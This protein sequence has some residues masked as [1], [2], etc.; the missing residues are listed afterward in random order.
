MGLGWAAYG[1]V[2][3]SARQMGAANR[4]ASRAWQSQGGWGGAYREIT[5]T[6]ALNKI[7]DGDA[8]NDDVIAYLR[9]TIKPAPSKRRATPER[10][11]MV[12]RQIALLERGATW[13]A[14]PRANDI[15][16]EVHDIPAE[17]DMDT[18]Y[19]VIATA[20]RNEWDRHPNAHHAVAISTRAR[21]AAVERSL[22]GAANA[23]K[24]NGY[25]VTDAVLS[26]AENAIRTTIAECVHEYFAQNEV[27]PAPVAAPAPA[28]PAGC[29]CSGCACSGCACSGC[30]CSGCACSGCA[31][32]GCACSG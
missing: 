19:E 15:K 20:A 32:S 28:A 30:A 31:C 12:E 6:V 22:E 24:S 2:R 9:W 11:A 10:T 29:A 18:L 21:E 7:L 26:V 25:L 27:A 23:L 5:G 13:T 1:S 8:T 14:K 17:I 4:A 16:I 3:R